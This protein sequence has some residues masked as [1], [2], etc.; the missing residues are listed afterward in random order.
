MSLTMMISSWS[1]PLTTVSSSM[2]SWAR[3]PK[4]S[5]NIS[6][7]RSGVST[8]PGRRG[9]SPIPSRISRIP[10]EICPWSNPSGSGP[11]SARRRSVMR[12]SSWEGFGVDLGLQ[13]ADEREVAEPFV[14]V[15]PVAHDEHRRDLEAAVPDVERNLLGLGL[16]QQ[17]AHLEAGRLASPEVL[18]Q[19]VQ[20][21]PRVDD[22]LDQQDVPPGDL[23]V[24]VLEDPHHARRLRRGAV[25]GHGHEVELHR[26]L[27][28]AGDVGHQDERALQHPHED[29]VAAPVVLG[30]PLPQLPDLALDLVAGDEDLFDLVLVGFHVYPPGGDSRTYSLSRRAASP[31]GSDAR[32]P[33]GF[34][35]NARTASTCAAS[36]EPP[37]ERIARTTTREAS[38]RGRA[39]STSAA[40]AVRPSSAKTVA[41]A[42]SA[43]ASSSPASSC[44]RPAVRAR[45]SVT[46]RPTAAS[47][48]GMT[49]V[50]TATRMNAGSSFIGS[51]RG[52]SPSE[53]QNATV[54][55]RRTS[56]NGR[57]TVPVTGRIAATASSPPPRRSARRTVSAWSSAVWPTAARRSEERR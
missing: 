7:T 56:S 46:L 4:T 30:D 43:S 10:S 51:W 55:R 16:L 40:S 41:S 5:S 17:R 11:A 42:W 28:V 24:E 14:E 19:V 26:Q 49:R 3:P 33:G 6:A 47:S 37:S 35:A 31:P 39:S 9:S 52:R 57:T 27:D 44:S 1:A 23:V 38:G 25:R 18:Q 45:A 2:G 8:I 13:R 15:E 53:R 48:C 12:T 29:Q 32:R 21:E 54:S 50:R 34:A 36:G 20:R 22:V